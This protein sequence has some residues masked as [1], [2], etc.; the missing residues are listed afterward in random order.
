MLY[1]LLLACR[2]T[3]AA[4]LFL[5]AVT[6]P[7]TEPVQALEGGCLP[8]S[9]YY[10]ITNDPEEDPY[11]DKYCGGGGCV[12]CSEEPEA[13]CNAFGKDTPEGWYNPS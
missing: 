6:Y 13:V 3:A 10:C 5:V 4:L 7:G 12:T 9:D 8:K 11:P 2:T 1:Q